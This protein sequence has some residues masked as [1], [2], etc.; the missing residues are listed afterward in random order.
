MRIYKSSLTPDPIPE[1][2]IA[3]YLYS[4][5]D[6]IPPSSPA[7][8]DADTG[9]TITREQL[10]VLS[11]ELGWSMCN[12][13]VKLGGAKL[14]RGDTVAIFSPN[15]LAYPI[16]VHGCFMAGLRVTV[17]NPSYKPAELAHQFKDSSAKVLFVHP[18]LLQMALSMFK[19]MKIGFKEVKR[20]IIIL[21]YDV[22]A[23]GNSGFIQLEKL[24]GKGQ[25]VLEE[26][27]DGALSKETALICYSSGTTGKPK[28]VEL[29]HTNLIAMCTILNQ[30][31]EIEHGKD[32]TL[33]FLPFY[34]I[35]GA[36]L[37]LQFFF[38]KGIP[39][40]VMERFD[41]VEFLKNI[42]KYRITFAT[43]VPPIMVI[44]AR[45]PAATTFNLTSL[46]LLMCGAAPLSASLQHAVKARLDS[47]GV[48]APIVQA[49]GMTEA[50]PSIHFYGTQDAERKVGA[51]GKLLAGMEAR[52]V[53]EDGITDAG[54]GQQGE[55]WVRGPIVMKGYLNNPSATKECLLEDG[56]LKTG[57]IATVDDEGYFRI[58]DRRKEL[59]KYK[60]FQA[61]LEGV[62]LEH[63]EIADA[64]VVGVYSDTEA[65]ELPRAYVVHLKGLRTNKEKAE[66]GKQVQEWMRSR[67]ARHK[68]LRGGVVVIDVIPKSP[69]GKI[70]RR[71]LRERAKSEAIALGVD[72]QSRTKL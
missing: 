3:S 65:T 24:L 23:P 18:T 64:G 27:F 17:A 1:I 39:V 55:L 70:L 11:S 20:R 6:P 31:N 2:S 57:D 16:A 5:H 19:V 58:V 69:S 45:H 47:I 66:F 28:G 72:T 40:I 4:Q 36:V 56:W 50:A 53:L 14:A 49:Y 33:G 42:E 51:V 7:F 35:Y 52:L 62:L 32:R 67:V 61:E 13:L 30:V 60:A 68:Y 25:L 37:L 46:K 21:R 54:E 22:G 29:M 48:K 44:L 10:R 34:H 9:R 12:G 8:V 38:K 59:I 41:A 63:P 43:C 15:C 26:I 71:E